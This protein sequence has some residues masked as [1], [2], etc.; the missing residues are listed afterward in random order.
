MD[1]RFQV[2]YSEGKL[3]VFRILLDT[4]TGVQYLQTIQAGSGSTSL[5]VLVDEEG[6]P[7]L[8]PQ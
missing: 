4:E 5:T 8:H 6:K 1:N 3:D 2:I 7:L